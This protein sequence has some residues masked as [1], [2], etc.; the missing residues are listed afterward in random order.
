MAF[1]SVDDSHIEDCTI[2]D[3]ND[4]AFDLDHFTTQTVVRHCHATHCNVGVELND[5]ND[6]IV[7]ACEFREC[8]TGVNLWRW[9]KMPELNQ[10]NRISGNEF[11]GTKGNGIQIATGTSKNTISDNEIRDSVRSGISL[12]ESEQIVHGNKISGSKRKNLTVNEGRH[13]I[14]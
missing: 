5:A 8:G 2:M 3:T 4:E 9:C 14:Q 6:C 10:G 7:E 1:Y 12:A 11:T 13:D